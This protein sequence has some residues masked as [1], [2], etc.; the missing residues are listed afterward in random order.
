MEKRRE[1]R[2]EE[3]RREKSRCLRVMPITWSAACTAPETRHTAPESSF[4]KE[5]SRAGTQEPPPWEAGPT[6]ACRDLTGTFV[7][8][9][10]EKK[11]DALLAA[12][13]AGGQGR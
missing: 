5:D 3:K 12:P 1:K 8:I 4:P 10:R 13:H 6:A 2:R 7:Q 11:L 9:K